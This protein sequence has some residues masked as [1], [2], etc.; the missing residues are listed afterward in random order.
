M[1]LFFS[2]IGTLAWTILLVAAIVQRLRKKPGRLWVFAIGSFVISMAATAFI[3][4]D[5]SSSK[6]GS[7]AS[8]PSSV[9][10]ASEDRATVVSEPKVQET[11]VAQAKSAFLSSVNGSV[12][13]AKVEGN[14][15][16]YVG[17][18][19]KWSCTISNVVSGNADSFANAQCGDE[20][21]Q[22][23]LIGDRISGLD[24]KQQLVVVGEVAQPMEGTN[25]MGGQLH[26]PTINM[27]YNL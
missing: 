2:V 25:A 8:N 10:S 17:T 12:T 18:A 21:S 15:T 13:P 24:A 27:K 23:V 19:V 6:S 14:P 11:T 16:K 5:P 1:A 20:S 7:S 4:P 22:I 3:P 9:A 26:F